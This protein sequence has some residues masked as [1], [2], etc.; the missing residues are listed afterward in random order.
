MI[1]N[2]NPNW[3]APL[4]VISG[5]VFLFFILI[6]AIFIPEPSSFQV[7]VFRVV[8]A[9]AAA[10]FGATVPGFLNVNLPVW[11]KGAIAAGGALALFV[12]IFNINPPEILPTNNNVE[13]ITPYHEIDI[14]VTDHTN[15]DYGDC[16]ANNTNIEGL[17]FDNSKLH[18]CN[19]QETVISRAKFKG[20]NVST[21]DFRN[22]DGIRVS[23]ENA[24]ALF[25]KFTLAKL[26]GANFRGA[27]LTEAEF[28]GADLREAN[29]TEANMEGAFLAGADITG[30]DFTNVKNLTQEQVNLTIYDPSFHRSIKFPPHLIAPIHTKKGA[31]NLVSTHSL[32]N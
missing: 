24:S 32:S 26:H 27:N 13:I 20:A 21:A 4:S 22:V 31:G 12:I 11:G 16:S 23:F 15:K 6:A 30:A 19:F 5:L 28:W 2:Q 9:L 17:I 25:T 18:G 14:E 10:S 7:F 29:F 1:S 3:Y 8:I